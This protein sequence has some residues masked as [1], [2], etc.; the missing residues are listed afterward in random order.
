MLKTLFGNV[1][2]LFRLPLLCLMLAACG[3]G[4]DGQSGQGGAQSGAPTVS[5]TAS[6]T[7]VAI[8]GSSMLTWSSTDAISCSA[9]GAWS[10]TKAASGNQLSAALTTTTAFNLA[11]TGPG[12]NASTSVIVSVV[13]APGA[14][15]AWV[16]A[17]AIGQW[18]QIPNT[19]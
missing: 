15:P 17:L 6:P 4:S 10:G 5:L 13:P 11:C 18:F 3:G 7:S 9:S 1:T 12:G 8:G 19:A 14:L 16:N 2:R